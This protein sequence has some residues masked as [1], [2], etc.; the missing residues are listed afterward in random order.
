MKLAAINRP[1]FANVEGGKRLFLVIFWQLGEVKPALD[2]TAAPSEM[3]TRRILSNSS[4]VGF[5][6]LHLRQLL[7]QRKAREPLRIFTLLE[8]RVLL[9]KIVPQF[10][11]GIT[12][13]AASE[14]KTGILPSTLFH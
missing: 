3:P 8:T 9:W 14:A 6:N 1:S 10:Q 5:V 4:A 2:A 13:L 12:F 7:F 11:G